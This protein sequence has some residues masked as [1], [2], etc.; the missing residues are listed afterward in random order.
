M[1]APFE[2]IEEF[3]YDRHLILYQ[4][5]SKR[6]YALN[7]TGQLVWE[8]YKKGFAEESIADHLA[9]EFTISGDAALKDVETCIA[10]WKQ[11]GIFDPVDTSVDSS[12]H[13]QVLLDTVQ[14]GFALPEDS[15]WYSRHSFKLAARTIRGAFGD[16]ELEK[17][18]IPI[19]AHLEV[20]ND[21]A[22]QQSFGIWHEKGNFFVALNNGAIHRTDSLHQAVGWI[23]FDL[24]DQACRNLDCMAVLHGGAVRHGDSALILAGSKGSGKST[25]IACAAA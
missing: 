2:S 23:L 5:V 13:R 21:G 17:T 18:L 1:Q 15:F 9:E 25:L 8:F 19:L 12:P 7:S 16:P 11:A 4:Q 6:L 24:V 3:H 10:A 14:C 22:A 20:G